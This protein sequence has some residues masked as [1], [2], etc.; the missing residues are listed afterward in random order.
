MGMRLARWVGRGVSVLVMFVVSVKVLVVFGQVKPYSESH[1]NCREDKSNRGV[2]ASG[3][4]GP[5]MPHATIEPASQ[6]AS[7]RFS[8]ASRAPFGRRAS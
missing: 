4:N 2:H 7:A 5:T 1:Q 3:N 8:D 6:G